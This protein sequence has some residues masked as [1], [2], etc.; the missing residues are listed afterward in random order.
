MS[1]AARVPAA[2]QRRCACGG[3]PG[4]GGECAACKA[5]RLQRQPVGAGPGVAPPV[6]HEVLGSPGRPLEP[7]LR[8]EMEARFGHDFS[9]VRV[10]ADSHAAAS[11]SAVSAL[12]YTVGSDVVFGASGRHAL[13]TPAGTHLLAHELAHVQQ[14]AGTASPAV[15]PRLGVAESGST[16]EREADAAADA[17]VGGHAVPG[18]P[19]AAGIGL[20]RKPAD[21]DERAKAVAEAEAVAA[22]LGQQLKD[23]DKDDE[24]DTKAT[25][26]PDKTPLRFRPGGFTDKEADAL[27]QEAQARVKLGSAALTLA[28]RQ[29]RRH[30]FWDGNP[31]Y[32]SADVKE[33]FDLDLYW[34]PK[35]EGFVR[36]PYVSKT[37][38]AILADPE[39][40]RLYSG[41]LWDLTENKPEK[42]SW[43]KRTMDF[44]CKYTEPCSSNLEEFRRDRES[45]MSRD[46][47]L[48]R[49]MARLTVTAE[50]MMLPGPGPSGPIQ[51]PPGA[52]PT[53]GT[54]SVP[55]PE[56][57]GPS[58]GADIAPT[59]KPLQTTGGAGGKPPPGPVETPG[60]SPA[61]K[62]ASPGALE[63]P[64]TVT[65]DSAVQSGR[66]PAGGKLETILRSIQAEFEAAP[67][68]TLRQGDQLVSRAAARAGYAR[69]IKTQPSA[70]EI[71]LENV[72]GVKTRILTSGEIIVT[73]KAG[74]VVLRLIP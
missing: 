4:P 45:G 72:G 11:A 51:L 2:L 7:G 53:G 9:Q 55:V 54:F 40:K 57:A 52:R 69:G 23:A 19:R 41:R 36:Q 29:A 43:F 56:G 31:S 65:V 1:L 24:P 63:R 68:T 38:D 20:A 12:A 71:V 61:P 73:N 16:L 5:K 64:G 17:V 21:D 3:T 34:D 30:E 42:K 33:A 46:E 8:G 18:N 37:E 25:T 10:H 32:N 39:A 22:R 6:V 15:M 60:P 26:R 14:Q 44:V 13:G 47:A 62:V 70:S 66:V 74:Q 48:N 49:G 28:E 35:E 67:S 27:V 58:V 59:S 50:T